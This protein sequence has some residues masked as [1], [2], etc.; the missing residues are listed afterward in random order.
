MSNQSAKHCPKLNCES[1]YNHLK[2]LTI[3]EWNKLNIDYN[4]D[5]KEGLIVKFCKN[6][7]NLSI[8]LINSVETLNTITKNGANKKKFVINLLKDLVENSDIIE[9][10]HKSEISK[11][12]ELHLKHTID[13]FID[14]YKGKI[15]LNKSVYMKLLKCY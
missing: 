12:I 3:I 4:T 2:N 10:S 6:I 9:Y 5:E 14:I 13:I 15:K 11:F 1:S 8:Y 7:Q